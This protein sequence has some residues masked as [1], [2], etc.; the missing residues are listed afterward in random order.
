MYE[1][2]QGVVVGGV[3]G[4]EAKAEFV[5]AILEN[6]VL[7]GGKDAC[8]MITQEVYLNAVAAVSKV[9]FDK[10]MGVAVIIGDGVISWIEFIVKVKV[11]P[12]EGAVFGRIPAA[13]AKDKFGIFFLAVGFRPCFHK[14][15]ISVIPVPIQ[16]RQYLCLYLILVLL[17]F[18][19]GIVPELGVKPFI[20]C[21]KKQGKKRNP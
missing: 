7:T 21:C 13:V 8:P 19:R 18:E 12:E 14:G 2:V 9:G 4:K 3:N 11:S 1:I 20:A 6:T 17:H 10:G 16:T 15:S 5:G